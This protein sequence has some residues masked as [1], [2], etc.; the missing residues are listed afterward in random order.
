MEKKPIKK[1]VPVKGNAPAEE[2]MISKGRYDCMSLALRDTKAMLKEAEAEI[3]R[4]KQN[5]AALINALIV[6]QTD[7]HLAEVGAKNIVAARALIDFSKIQ[8]QNDGNVTGVTEQ[9]EVLKQ[10]Q[11]FLFEEKCRYFVLKEV[12]A[13]AVQGE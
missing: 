3:T 8:L 12:S 6:A 1:S 9:I 4:L 13:G 11:S 2:V 7:K 5:E 10:N